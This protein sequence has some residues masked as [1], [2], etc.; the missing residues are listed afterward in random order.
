MEQ[1]MIK[2]L[3][4]HAI[5]SIALQALR[6]SV[7]Y[8]PSNVSLLERGGAIVCANHVS[9]LDGIII[10]MASPT[11]LIFAV[12]TDF[13]RRSWIARRGMSALTSLGFG[14]IV[15]IDATAPHGIR[16]LAKALARNQNVMV[17]P[18]GRISDIA[19]ALPYQ[20]GLSW[21]LGRTRADV[22]WVHI[23]GAERSRFFAKAGR[24]LW[25]HIEIQF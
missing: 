17:F 14:A 25:P 1:T 2:S 9:L 8:S 6:V 12:D 10:A 4:R 13:S 18:E 5:R 15:P 19:G 11:P 16:T 21:L 23:V 22:V 7:S 24:T 3:I 20:P